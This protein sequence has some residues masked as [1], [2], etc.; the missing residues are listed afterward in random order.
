MQ[1]IRGYRNIKK[2]KTYR[3]NLK[4]LNS[5]K[6]SSKKFFDSIK[7]FGALITIF[8]V[9]VSGVK[10][11]DYL[12]KSERF[13]IRNIISNSE[14]REWAYG[15]ILKENGVA[16]G[17]NIFKA[18]LRNSAKSIM[19]DSNIAKVKIKRKFPDT[20][21]VEVIDRL[22]YAYIGEDSLYQIDK[23]GV[24][25]L[26]KQLIKKDIPVISGYNVNPEEI[27]KKTRSEKLLKTLKFLKDIEN[28]ISNNKSSIKNVSHVNL[29]N[30]DSIEIKTNEAISVLFSEH[31]DHM[32]FDKKINMF[33]MLLGDLS[34]KGKNAVSV[35]LR[36][37]NEAAVKFK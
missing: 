24:I 34:A 27:G 9:I 7:R 4:S 23:D 18:E 26:S 3:I 29:S 37:R 5:K 1:K 12:I 33:E 14:N 2:I 25:T 19:L 20:I 21:I 28:Y 31:I 17:K 16:I 8:S 6:K 36:F 22:P 35:D 15:N 30:S 13:N 10:I 11:Y 32:E